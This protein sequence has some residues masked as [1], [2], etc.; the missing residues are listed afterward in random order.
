M[1][2]SGYNNDQTHRHRRA[3][4]KSLL[5]YGGGRKMNNK[6]LLI[7]IISIVVF[8]V[9]DLMTGQGTQ[10]VANIETAIRKYY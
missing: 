4:Q 2:V 6:L 1:K 9:P 7:M 5:I 8:S 3:K 10:I